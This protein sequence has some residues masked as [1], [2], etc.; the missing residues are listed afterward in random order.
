MVR[1]FQMHRSSSST[2]NS[3]WVLPMT[4]ASDC[5][6]LQWE[7]SNG[8]DGQADIAMNAYWNSQK[9]G[10][11]MNTYKQF[12]HVSSAEESPFIKS[13]RWSLSTVGEADESSGRWLRSVSKMVLGS[14]DGQLER[15]WEDAVLS[16]DSDFFIAPRGVFSW[17][18]SIA[19]PV[20]SIASGKGCEGLRW[21]IVSVDFCRGKR[22]S[23]A[24]MPSNELDSWR[25]LLLPS[26]VSFLLSGGKAD[27]MLYQSSVLSSS[28]WNPAW[29]LVD[30]VSGCSSSG[31]KRCSRIHLSE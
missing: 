30:T 6:D 4:S 14:E 20:S 8:I 15:G 7:T 12:T 23:W 19:T 1:D 11:S 24:S 5:S 26:G 13:P 3:Y 25:S 29:S 22:S 16:L 31:S 21:S 17:L 18:D 28:E 27:A 9:E 10:I 2:R